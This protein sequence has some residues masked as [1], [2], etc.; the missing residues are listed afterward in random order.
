MRSQVRGRDAPFESLTSWQC[1][2]MGGLLAADTFLA[3]VNS[4]PDKAAP[5]WP[6]IIAC[7]AFDTPVCVFYLAKIWHAH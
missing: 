1:L 6:K 3:M 5:L 4:R 2:S 7:L